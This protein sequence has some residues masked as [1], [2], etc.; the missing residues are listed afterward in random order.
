[1][2]W[3]RCPGRLEKPTEACSSSIAGSRCWTFDDGLPDHLDDGRRRPGRHGDRLKDVGK[4]IA[5]KT[6]TTNDERMP[7]FIGFSPD[8]VVGLY[9]GYDKPRISAGPRT[10]VTSPLRSPGIS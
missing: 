2:S 1:M 6:G 3:L 9:L 5:G 8:I 4:P 7:W 10:P